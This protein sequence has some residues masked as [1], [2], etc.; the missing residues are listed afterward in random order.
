[1]QFLQAFV[2]PLSITIFIYYKKAVAVCNG[3]AV[4]IEGGCAVWI[5]FNEISIGLLEWKL[6]CLDEAKK[7]P[8]NRGS[9]ELQGG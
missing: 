7:S 3:C 2:W 6:I 4:N 9:I 5:G 1:M 8:I